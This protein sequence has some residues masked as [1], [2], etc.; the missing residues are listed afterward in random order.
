MRRG[1]PRI[2]TGGGTSHA[3]EQQHPARPHLPVLSF[4]AKKYSE[5]ACSF[6]R[7]QSPATP[8]ALQFTGKE[9]WQGNLPPCQ[10][11]HGMRQPHTVGGWRIS[12]HPQPHTSGGL[13]PAGEALRAAALPLLR[14]QVY[15]QGWRE[16]VD[17]ADHDGLHNEGLSLLGDGNKVWPGRRDNMAPHAPLGSA[18]AGPALPLPGAA[19]IFGRLGGQAL[20]AHGVALA[21]LGALDAAA[22]CVGT[23]GGG[24]AGCRWRRDTGRELGVP[25]TS[26]MARRIPVRVR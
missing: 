2:K 14:Q 10:Q 1:A 15:L 17:W 26:Q 22:A 16:K 20:E 23:L 7:T 12:A 18:A 6:C 25:S 8:S 3:S 19:Y 9:A 24:G 4:G 11:S 21:L 5:R 13:C